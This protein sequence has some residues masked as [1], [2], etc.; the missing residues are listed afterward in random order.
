MQPNMWVIESL[1]GRLRT[2]PWDAE[3]RLSKTVTSGEWRVTSDPKKK[4]GRVPTPGRFPLSSYPS[5]L[6]TAI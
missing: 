2:Y 6:V 1:P 4:T 3:G 5:L